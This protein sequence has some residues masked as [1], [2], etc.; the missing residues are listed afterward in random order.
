MNKGDYYVLSEAF[1][2]QEYEGLSKL[3]QLTLSAM[4]GE[5]INKTALLKLVKTSK[6]WNN[7]ERFYYVPILLILI[8]VG[9]RDY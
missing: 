2:K 7:L 3:E 8:K 5:A 1:W 9:L 4:T 6:N